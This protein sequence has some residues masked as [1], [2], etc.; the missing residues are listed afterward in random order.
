MILDELIKTNFEKC[1][2]V[3][4]IKDGVFMYKYIKRPD[5]HRS[6]FISR[7]KNAY[8]VLIGKSYTHKYLDDLSKK[9]LG[10]FIRKR[11]R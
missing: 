2:L 6:S 1:D 7:I 10:D 5:N 8:S 11:S 4:P 3:Y 9:E